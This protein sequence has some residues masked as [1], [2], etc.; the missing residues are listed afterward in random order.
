MFIKLC[1]FPERNSRRTIRQTQFDLCALLI[2][3]DGVKEPPFGT[4]LAVTAPLRR[5]D[6]EFKF[7]LAEPQSPRA[8]EQN[9][10]RENRNGGNEKRKNPFQLHVQSSGF[11][12]LSDSRMNL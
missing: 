9:V 1:E 6:D 3:F 8:V 4:A 2:K 11:Q 10:F 12:F 5:E 7:M